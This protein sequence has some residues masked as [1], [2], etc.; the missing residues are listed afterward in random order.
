[1]TLR[2]SAD[3]IIDKVE[4]DP[5]PGMT[6]KK[7][8]WCKPALVVLARSRPEEVLLKACKTTSVVGSG[9]ILV[10]CLKKNK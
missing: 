6:T 1:M 2:S 7:S 5:S 3:V 4:R 10:G 9:S 8:P